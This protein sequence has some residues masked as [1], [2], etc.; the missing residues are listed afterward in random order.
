VEEVGAARGTWATT[1]TEKDKCDSTG[2]RKAW[3]TQKKGGGGK[4]V[5]GGRGEQEQ[6][7]GVRLIMSRE[8]SSLALK[9]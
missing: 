6:M 8:L 5:W 2:K 9:G 7:E 3:S 1:L 4:K